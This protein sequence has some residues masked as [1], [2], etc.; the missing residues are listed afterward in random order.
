MDEFDEDV[1]GM[2]TIRGEDSIGDVAG[3]GI[4]NVDPLITMSG[5]VACEGN[6]VL[7]SGIPILNC[8]E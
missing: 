4:F 2:V 5:G 1:G 8:C 6:T 3:R 7:L